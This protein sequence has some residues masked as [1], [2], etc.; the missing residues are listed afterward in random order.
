MFNDITKLTNEAKA[1]LTDFNRTLDNGEIYIEDGNDN[2]VTDEILGDIESLEKKINVLYDD[3]STINSN[4]N[5]FN[6]DIIKSKQ[7]RQEELKDDP[8]SEGDLDIRDII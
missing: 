3:I 5:S 7:I 4:I 8:Y 2:K 1:N 6:S